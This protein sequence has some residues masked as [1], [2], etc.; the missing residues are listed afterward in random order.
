MIVNDPTPEE[1]GAAI[2]QTRGHSHLWKVRD[3]AV[4]KDCCN[5][6][7][8]PV[9]ARSGGRGDLEALGAMAMLEHT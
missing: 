3:L 8:S 6:D 2:G 1:V 5:L 9:S 4:T 7:G